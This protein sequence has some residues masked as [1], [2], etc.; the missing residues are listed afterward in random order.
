MTTLT[1]T[2]TITDSTGVTFSFSGV[3][4]QIAP[5]TATIVITPAVAPVG[6]LRNLTVTPS[7]GVP[8]Y[9]FGT[10]TAPGLTFTPVPNQPGQWTF[11][12]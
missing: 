12:Y 1:I 11:V 4:T 10:P 3:A 2:G 9:A 7:G 8:P 5:I 6:T